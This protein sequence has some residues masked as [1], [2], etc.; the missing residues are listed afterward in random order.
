MTSR[1]K[2]QLQA[3]ADSMIKKATGQAEGEIGKATEKVGEDAKKAI[4]DFLGSFGKK[5]PAPADTGRSVK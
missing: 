4:G 5:K 3:Q 1:A 2:S